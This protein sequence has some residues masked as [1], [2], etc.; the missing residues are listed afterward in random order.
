M[1]T[2]LCLLSSCLVKAV[3]LLF[4]YYLYFIYFQREFETAEKCVFW[5]G[6]AGYLSWSR[7]FK[8]KILTE[9]VGS[10]LFLPKLLLPIEFSVLLD[11]FPQNFFQLFAVQTQVVSFD[12][13]LPS[14][15]PPCS[16][17]LNCRLPI[18]L[19][20]KSKWLAKAMRL[21][22]TRLI[23]GLC[24][25]HSSPNA[26][27]IAL[28]VLGRGQALP[29]LTFA[30]AL[31]MPRVLLVSLFPCAALSCPRCPI[32]YNSSFFGNPI[33][34]DVIHDGHI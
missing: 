28:L 10:L 15:Y 22:V 33:L 7:A 5:G 26:S 4:I 8:E 18:A 11:L 12:P 9:K 3:F 31:T 2:S 29:P 20:I 24:S 19:R 27:H 34:H 25:L 21:C 1:G 30:S 23:S 13:Y 17:P 14:R 32:H 6:W 16:R